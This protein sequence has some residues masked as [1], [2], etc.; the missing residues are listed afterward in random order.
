M[1]LKIYEQD[2]DIE[3]VHKY[4]S[5]ELKGWLN[6]LQYI[7]TEIDNLLKLYQKTTN[8]SIIPDDIYSFFSKRKT[9][10]NELYDTILSYSNTYMNVVECN[11]I[12]CD[13]A[14]LNEYERLRRTY[15]YHLNRYQKLK[16][17]LYKRAL[18]Y[19]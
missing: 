14:Y 19:V 2:S 1:T 11:D 7:N 9:Q 4:N 10:N 12:Q 16:D 3:V 18:Q 6:Q 17:V 15:Q 5:I 8:N 13:M